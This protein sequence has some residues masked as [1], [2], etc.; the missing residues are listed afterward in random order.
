MRL[1][2][3]LLPVLML[4]AASTRAATAF[5]SDELVLGVYAEQN[6]QGQRL[7]TL[8]SGASVDT[9]SVN[10]E[11]TQVR[12]ADGTTGWVKTIYLTTVVPATVRVKQLEEELD[13]RRATTP[14]LAEAAARSE[15]E[16][17]KRE[18]S[19]TQA[20]LDAATQLAAPTAAAPGAATMAA[21]A[22]P[23][24]VL[25]GIAAAAA[26]RP[27]MAVVPLLAALGCGFWL[28]Y[29]TLARRIKRKFG[30]LK[31]Y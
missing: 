14:A 21:A 8:H 23:A 28:G 1:S 7:A 20:A 29:A 22:A 19:N 3:A 2:T 5:V 24:G 15:V 6:G 11:Y 31:V 17:L 10:G 18:L 26:K 12:L 4:A 13:R 30:G 16:Q 25:A 27:W 9:L